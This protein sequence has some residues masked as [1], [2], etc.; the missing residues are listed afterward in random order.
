MKGLCA[1]KREDLYDWIVEITKEEKS[2]RK[3]AYAFLGYVHY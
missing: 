2:L 1:Y 3:L